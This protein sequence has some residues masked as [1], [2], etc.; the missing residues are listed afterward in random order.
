MSDAKSLPVSNVEVILALLER[1]SRDIHDYVSKPQ[2]QPFNAEAVRS[3]CA[4]LYAVSEELVAM[5]EA[6]R[7][8]AQSDADAKG[9]APAEA[10]N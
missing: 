7:A 5:A 8:K 3:E 10:V 4:K 9:V 1:I 2:P 6:A